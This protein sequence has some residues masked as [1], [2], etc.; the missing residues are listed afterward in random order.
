NDVSFC[1]DVQIS[2]IYGASLDG[3]TVFWYPVEFAHG[4]YSEAWANRT[5][6][7]PQ[8]GRA[9]DHVAFSV[10]DLD[11]AVARLRAEGVVLLEPAALRVDGQLRSAFIA[12]PDG[13]TVEIV[14]GHIT[15]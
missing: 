1:N 8:R 12:A 5:A 14:E 13:V 2:P 15:P 3:V 6:F 10:E 4:Y 11:R 9:I 7:E